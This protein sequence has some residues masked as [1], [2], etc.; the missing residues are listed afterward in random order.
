MIENINSLY[1]SKVDQ[2]VFAVWMAYHYF[3]KPLKYIGY[4]GTGKQ[5]RDFLDVNDLLKLIDIQI[6][7][8]DKFS[9]QTYN[10]G[11]GA[12]N[13][14]SLYETTQLCQEI[15][16]HKVAI[17]PITETRV[18]DIPIFI[19]DSRRVIAA[20]GWQPQKDA[21][22]TLTEIYEWI[23]QSEDIVKDIFI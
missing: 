15:T 23:H 22:T 4:G 1:G 12:Q 13:V 20:T 9:G 8:L 16:G 7:R 17:A 18:G 21:K 14:L 6:Q 11:G 3:Q 2:G 5:I 19:T 10:V